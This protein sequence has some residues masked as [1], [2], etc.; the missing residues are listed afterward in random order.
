MR[1]PSNLTREEI[2]KSLDEL[3]SKIK[4]LKARVNAT[5]ADSNH[6]YHEHIAALEAKRE[7]IAQ[8]LGDSDDSQGKWQGLRDG[9][10]KLKNDMD[11][12]FK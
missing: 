1:A 6:T 5:A 12:L 2:E 7:L 11:N 4:T 9:L 8:K 3:D 10:D